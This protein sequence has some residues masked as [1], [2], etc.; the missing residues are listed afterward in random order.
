[1]SGLD[2]SPPHTPARHEAQGA[3][4][5]LRAGEWRG[6]RLHEVARWIRQGAPD[7]PVEHQ[8]GAAHR[9]DHDPG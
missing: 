4:P 7:R 5:R 3:L 6:R 8:P 2:R 9:V 1:M